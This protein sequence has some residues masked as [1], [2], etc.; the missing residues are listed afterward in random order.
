MRFMAQSI[1]FRGNHYLVAI[2]LLTGED[3][4]P[5]VAARNGAG[6]QVLLALTSP[7]TAE[8]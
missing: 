8:S 6:W 2:I 5:I 3:I 7:Y 4:A 1:P